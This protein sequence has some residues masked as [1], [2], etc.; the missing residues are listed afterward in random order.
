MTLLARWWAGV[1]QLL[2]IITFQPFEQ[3][4]TPQVPI[5]DHDLEPTRTFALASSSSQPSPSKPVVTLSAGPTFTPPGAADTNFT[6]D[7]SKMVG[8]RTCSTSEDRSCWLRH[9]D[10]GQFDIETN[11]EQLRPQG[12]LRKYYIEIVDNR[13]LNVDGQVFNE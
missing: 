13:T 9:P 4:G 8:W 10:I 7:Y 5:I 1:T 3:D 12:V 11:Y 6:C 2:S